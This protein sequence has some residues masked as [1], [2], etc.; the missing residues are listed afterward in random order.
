MD[1]G[2]P[3]G[4]PPRDGEGADDGPPGDGRDHG[5]AVTVSWP[6]AGVGVVRA[7][8]EIDLLTASQ[9]ARTL[10][11]TCHRLARQHD[12]PHGCGDGAGRASGRAHLV[13][14][15][16]GVGFFGACGLTAL[17]ETAALTATA[18]VALRLIADHPPVLRPLRI[19]GLDRVLCV[20]AY[21]ATAITHALRRRR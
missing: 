11:D 19:T 16:T 13:C 5:L 3:P 4:V 20:D 17:V 14:D 9:W 7:I 6:A 12:D 1:T 10:D 21:L 18:G 15:L 8:G 2:P